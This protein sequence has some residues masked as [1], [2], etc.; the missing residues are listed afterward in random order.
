M[1][2]ERGSLGGWE[3]TRDPP[4]IQ[5]SFKQLF[6][7]SP[8]LT[9]LASRILSSLPPSFF[10]VHLRSTENEDSLKEVK[11][12]GEVEVERVG[13]REG[14]RDEIGEALKWVLERNT[15]ARPVVYV[16]TEDG[17]TLDQFIKRSLL[18]S[19]LPSHKLSPS[20]SS[21]FSSHSSFSR[22]DAEWM[23]MNLEEDEMRVIDHIVM[24]R[25]NYYV[26]TGGS[27]DS[28][29]LGQ[30]RH[31]IQFGNLD[32]HGMDEQQYLLGDGVN[33][34]SGTTW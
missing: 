9:T 26:G 16:S 8:A 21:S 13:E 34:W 33:W 1:I 27:V 32:Y 6:R 5:T 31:F 4:S 19:I 22:Q 20:P 24:M 28:Y 14:E 7:F 30:N 15:S 11:E 3:R 18:L 2:Q 12:E 23:V 17:R 29:M 25:A 10:A